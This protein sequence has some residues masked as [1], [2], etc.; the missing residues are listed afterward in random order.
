MQT[1][2][3]LE[4]SQTRAFTSVTAFAGVMDEPVFATHDLANQKLTNSMVRADIKRHEAESKHFEARTKQHVGTL[5][6][7]DRH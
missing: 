4:R 2:S 7:T 1:R 6:S 5:A 3:F